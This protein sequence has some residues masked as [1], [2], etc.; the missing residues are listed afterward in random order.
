[1]SGEDINSNNILAPEKSIRTPSIKTY[2][3]MRKKKTT[4]MKMIMM[5]IKLMM[6]MKSRG[7]LNVITYRPSRRLI[8]YLMLVDDDFV[9]NFK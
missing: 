4:T 6:M 5:T 2:E 9:A 7:G 1:M 3:L 8:I